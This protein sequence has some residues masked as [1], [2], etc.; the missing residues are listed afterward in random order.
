MTSLWDA[1]IVQG[2]MSVIRGINDSFLTYF[3]E[4]SDL[5]FSIVGGSKYAV[6]VFVHCKS[7]FKLVPWV[8][9]G[10]CYFNNTSMFET[11]PTLVS[12]FKVNRLNVHLCL[13]VPNHYFENLIAPFCNICIV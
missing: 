9:P 10:M 13:F 8:E 1:K 12:M 2:V 5:K 7:D 6:P 4:S 3:Q 11:Q